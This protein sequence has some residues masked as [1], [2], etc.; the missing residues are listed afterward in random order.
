MDKINL[1]MKSQ[2]KINAYNA[3]AEFDG[4][5]VNVKKGSVIASSV[6][7]NFRLAKLMK[8]LRSD[9]ELVNDESILI[10]DI[11]FNNLSRAA[12]FV[13]GYSVNGRVSDGELQSGVTAN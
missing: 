4:N 12:C 5:T 11:Q 1:Y 6:N 9:K 8:E 7:E 13:A 3:S 10:K 2:K